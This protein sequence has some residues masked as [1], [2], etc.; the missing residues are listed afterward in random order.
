MLSLESLQ[1]ILPPVVSIIFQHNDFPVAREHLP[2][3]EHWGVGK[4]YDKVST[5]EIK[6]IGSLGLKAPYLIK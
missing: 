4:V 2:L 3:V 5:R 1:S 6:L